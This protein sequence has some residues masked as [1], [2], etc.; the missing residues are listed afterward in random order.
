MWRDVICFGLETH[1]WTLILGYEV[2]FWV[3]ADMVNFNDKKGN[4]KFYKKRR[5]NFH[6]YHSS[7]ETNTYI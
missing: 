7:I 3:K 4:L 5:G 2:L 6:I 1:I